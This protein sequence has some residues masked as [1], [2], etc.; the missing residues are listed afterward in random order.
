MGI[1]GTQRGGRQGTRE[2]LVPPWAQAEEP[3][4]PV[5]PQRDGG[6]RETTGS[7]GCSP[8]DGALL[9]AHT[10]SLKPNRCLAAPL[11]H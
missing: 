11:A 10:G 9:Q 8:G 5:R 1:S 3:H 7:P 4:S 2:G 6:S